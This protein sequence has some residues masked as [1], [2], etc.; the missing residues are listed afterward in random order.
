M[1]INQKE[2][3]EQLRSPE[4][5]LESL[6]KGIFIM[7]GVTTTDLITETTTMMEAMA[8]DIE[9]TIEGTIII[10][11]TTIEEDTVITIGVMITIEEEATDL[12]ISGEMMIAV[13][14]ATAVATDGMVADIITEGV[15]VM[16]A[17]TTITGSRA[18]AFNFRKL[19]IADLA[20]GAGFDTKLIKLLSLEQI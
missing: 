6:L 16:A 20:N 17:V 15:A 12:V 2:E 13:M 9:E 11:D 5:E 1:N 14:A 19:K 7:T 10:E 3:K 4:T 18:Y 8:E